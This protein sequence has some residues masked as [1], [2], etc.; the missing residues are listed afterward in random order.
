MK[1]KQAYK[2]WEYKPQAP[3]FS[4]AEKEKVIEQAKTIIHGLEK[5]SN[6][7]SRIEMRANRIYL[8]ELVEQLK[9]EGA[10]YLKP[11]IDDKYLEV[12]Y[13]RI[14]LMD[15]VGAACTTDFQR[16]NG[17]WMSLY[18]GSLL[19]CLNSIETDGTWF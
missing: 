12:P 11:L 1:K 15:T 10:V 13:A 3:K 2:I 4:A 19:D 17:Q 7:V 6:Q 5:L 16:H 9:T 8:F 18:E 14:T